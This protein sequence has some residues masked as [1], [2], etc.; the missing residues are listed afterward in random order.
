MKYKYLLTLLL[1][2]LFSCKERE[3]EKEQLE[4]D[5]LQEQII[6]DY[7]KIPKSIDYNEDRKEFEEYKRLI[8]NLKLLKKTN[9]GHK[10]EAVLKIAESK[11]HYL[12]GQKE[13][14]IAQ[15]S[16]IKDEEYQILKKIYTASYLELENKSHEA[17]VI[18]NEV[19][20]DLS[21]NNTEF[22][23]CWQRNI[24]LV[25]SGNEDLSLEECKVE[26][27]PDNY[28]KKLQGKNKKDIIL[29]TFFRTFEI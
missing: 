12:F 11:I 26:N 28:F 21:K 2:I 25:L 15:I 29:D 10:N 14:A 20:T 17:S 4:K 9:Y 1:I 19:Y 27:L 7:Q 6:L 22:S 23:D 5:K 3:T 16:E 8:H 18:F 13:K 24:I